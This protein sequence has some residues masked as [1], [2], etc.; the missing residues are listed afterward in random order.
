MLS[1][2]SNEGDVVPDPFCGC[3]TTVE[4]AVRLQRRWVG[5]DVTYIAVDLIK[6]RLL[7]TYGKTIVSTYDVSGIP[8]DM[9]SAQSLFQRSPFEFERWPDSLAL[10][11][12][13]R[14]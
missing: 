2:S 8:K 14:V 10:I 5:I 11:F 12:T 13:Q 7:H 1:A 3:G 4:A 6:K 9:A